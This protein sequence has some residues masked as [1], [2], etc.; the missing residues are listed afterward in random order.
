MRLAALA[1]FFSSLIAAH[2]M[3]LNYVR[4]NYKLATQDKKTCKNIPFYWMKIHVL[5]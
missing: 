3:D 4:Q 5:K 1:L 2:Q